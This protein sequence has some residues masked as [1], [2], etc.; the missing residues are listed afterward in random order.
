[1]LDISPMIAII[2]IAIVALLYTFTGGLKGVIWVDAIQ[3][4]IYIGG[5]I[6]AVIYLINN[7]PGN[8]VEIL[9]STEIS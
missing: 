7:I 3:M 5:A 4:L 1:M 9:S 8:I 6:L 2:I